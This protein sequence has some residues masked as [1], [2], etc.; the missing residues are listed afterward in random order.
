LTR[1]KALEVIR[2]AG[3]QGDHALF[4]RTYIENRISYAIAIREF[5]DGAAWAKA[6]RARGAQ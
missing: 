1:A 6:I 3:A 2:A 4:A 5:R